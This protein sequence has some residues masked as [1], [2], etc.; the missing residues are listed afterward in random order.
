MSFDSILFDLDGTLWNTTD[1]V[2]ASWND[3]L[4]ALGTSRRIDADELSGYF[5]MPMLEIAAR[6]F[7]GKEHEY[8]KQA[9]DVMSEYEIRHLSKTGGILYPE[10]EDTLSYLSGK[11]R[12]FIVSNCQDG[13][14]QTFF[15]A[16]GL[17]KYFTGFECSGRTG[18]SKGE[19]NL[20]LMRRF[21]LRTPLFV[22]DTV[23]DRESAEVARIPFAYASYG[24]GE[25]SDYDYRLSALSELKEIV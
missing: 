17:E 25:V 7:P 24:F 13:Y 11:C 8:L 23:L 15:S 14:I 18:L 4:S 2:V 6:I 21:S 19:N 3:A 22:G 5:G 10:L 20:L 16:H 1:G 9:M 12:L